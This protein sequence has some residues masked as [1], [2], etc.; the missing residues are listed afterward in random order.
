MPAMHCTSCMKMKI[1]PI[2]SI[3][4]GFKVLMG[5]CR[6]QRR[7]VLRSAQ[8]RLRKLQLMSVLLGLLAACTTCFLLKSMSQCELTAVAVSSKPRL[9]HASRIREVLLTAQP[10]S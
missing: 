3:I 5:F 7:Q 6:L 9:S 8:A 4:A 1:C 2:F 10:K